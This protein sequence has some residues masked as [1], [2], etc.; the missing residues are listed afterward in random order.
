M[1]LSPFRITTLI[2]VVPAIC[3][4]VWW[5]LDRDPPYTR[6]NGQLIPSPPENCR[7]PDTTPRGLSQGACVTVNWD[8]KPVKNCKPAGPFNVTR[9]IKDSQGDLRPLPAT[10]SAYSQER[11]MDSPLVRSFALPAVLPVGPATYRSKVCFVC[12]PGQ[13]YLPSVFHPVCVGEGD[14]VPFVT[15]MPEPVDTHGKAG[16]QGPQGEPGVRGPA[17]TPN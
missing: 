1:A 5:L 16:P 9:S 12:N 15:E 2:L 6:S 4:T 3:I 14:D 7:L 13:E 10:R 8:I 11:H 17:G